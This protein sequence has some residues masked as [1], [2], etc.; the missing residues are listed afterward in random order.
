MYVKYMIKTGC[1]AYEIFSVNELNVRKMQPDKVIWLIITLYTSIS[2]ICF[3]ILL[4][5]A[6]NPEYFSNHSNSV[7]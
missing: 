3:F 4:L 1:L 5:F 2:S 6:D 7:R